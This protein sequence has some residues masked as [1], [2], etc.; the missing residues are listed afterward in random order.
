[1]A[2]QIKL[3]VGG[4]RYTVKSDESVE[5]LNELGQEFDGKI[6]RI[7]KQ[8]PTLSTTMVGILAA[9]EAMDEAKK[10]KAEVKRLEGLLHKTQPAKQQQIRLE[11]K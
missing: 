1:M 6:R 11:T 8:N 4:I 3:T 9:F 10:A 5:Y 2:N 7:T